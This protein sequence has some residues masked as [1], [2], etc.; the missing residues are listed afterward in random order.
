MR[1]YRYMA[2]RVLPRKNGGASP[3]SANR[4]VQDCRKGVA[5]STRQSNDCG[6][7]KR[8]GAVI[9]LPTLTLSLKR[10]YFDAI[11][12]GEKPEEYRLDTPYWRKRL[13]MRHYGRI[14]LTLGYP[15]ADDHERRIIKPWRGYVERTIQHPHFGPE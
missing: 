13:Y 3:A 10:E 7:R 14:V 2:S 12:N 11:K 8:E 15:R 4:V 9:E 5:G 1:K 6:Y